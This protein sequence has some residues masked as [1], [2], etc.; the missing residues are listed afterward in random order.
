MKLVEY[1]DIVRR[2]SRGNSSNEL[3][4]FED[5]LTFFHMDL[6]MDKLIAQ[7]LNYTGLTFLC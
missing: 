3:F 6:D 1:F 2:I 4:R 7:T 5:K